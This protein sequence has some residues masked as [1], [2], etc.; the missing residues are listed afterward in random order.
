MRQAVTEIVAQPGTKDNMMSSRSQGAQNLIAETP[1]L[2]NHPHAALRGSKGRKLTFALADFTRDF[3]LF[4]IL[5]RC[6]QKNRP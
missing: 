1:P 5:T 4:F 2:R 6:Y 3:C